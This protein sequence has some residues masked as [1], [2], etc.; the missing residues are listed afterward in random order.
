MTCDI[1]HSDN[2]HIRTDPILDGILRIR[3]S[4]SDHFPDRDSFLLN[5]DFTPSDSSPEINITFSDSRFSIT[6][7]NGDLLAT[8]TFRPSGC[9]FDMPENSHYYGFGEKFGTL[10]KRGDRLMMWN[11]DIYAEGVNE[12]VNPHATNVD[13]IYASVNFFI[14]HRCN[15]PL[16]HG[17][18]IDTPRKV[19]YD[20]GMDDGRTFGL[21]VD[22]DILDLYIID[23]PA[24]PDIIERYTS[25]TGRIPM[26]PLWSLGYHQCRWSYE[27]EDQVRRI[28]DSLREHR[29][30]CDS[31]WLD[32]DYMDNFKTFTVD[33]EKFP[34]LKQLSEDLKEQGLQTVANLDPGFAVDEDWNLAK[35]GLRNDYFFKDGDEPYKGRAWP[36]DIL[37]PDFR[38]PEV[39]DWFG[40]L[41][42][43]FADENALSGLWFDMNEPAD[44]RNQWTNPAHLAFGNLF[45][46]LE[47][48]SAANGWD[49]INPNRRKYFLTRSACAGSQRYSS[50]WTGD[51]MSRWEHLEASIPTLCNLGM[52]GMPF[53]GT[54]VGGFGLHCDGEL[55]TRWLQCGTFYPFFRNHT[56]INTSSQEPWV[57]GDKV[58]EICRRYIELRYRLL[59]YIYSAFRNAHETGMPVMRPMIL[60]FPGDERFAN[61]GRQFMFGEHFL[62]APVFFQGVARKRIKLPEGNWVDFETGVVEEGG[63]VLWERPP[64]DRMPIFIRGGAPVP[65]WPL[66]QSTEWIDRSRLRIDC[67]PG[68][69]AETVLYE[70]DGES[71]EHKSGAFAK[72]KLTHSDES[73]VRIFSRGVTEGT[74]RV[75]NRT[76]EVVFVGCEREPSSIDLI[77]SG[78]KKSLSW[79]SDERRGEISVEVSDSADGFRV[80]M[81]S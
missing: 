46:H 21:T 48:L 74:D 34:D 33:R 40:K 72:I 19:I 30:P 6:R 39:R 57:F 75:E 67:Y 78:Q 24:I 26:P 27:T 47:L 31:V 52:S 65:M 64:L 37:Y 44:N 54:D 50:I 1:H 12:Q 15:G 29:I 2:L 20:L 51:N 68:G 43:K 8:G 23:G 80:E 70:D 76:I 55:F 59:P 66:A 62:I 3:V 53:C 13:P 10:D 41:V 77:S 25:L 4:I 45:P 60:A 7:H 11:M 18:F 22:D 56:S 81:K 71:H 69:S 14:E 79:S 35:E 38:K 5:P 58:L 63:G 28:A 32:I 73:D 9:R 16:S 42:A 49:K 36:G 17:I 61:E